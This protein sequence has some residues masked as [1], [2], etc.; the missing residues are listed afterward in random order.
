MAILR[1]NKITACFTYFLLYSIIVIPVFLTINSN[2]SKSI[3]RIYN[4]FK[5]S[6]VK[7][8]ILVISIISLAGIPPLTGFL[9]K[10]IVIFRIITSK[11]YIILLPLIIGSYINLYYYLNIA[12]NLIIINSLSS[13]QTKRNNLLASTFIT[14]SSILGLLPLIIYALIT[15]NKS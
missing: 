15:I 6:I 3:K 12:L 11:I 7:R 2:N 4:S 1:I 10:L 13:Y 14:G 8:I 9:P 5:R